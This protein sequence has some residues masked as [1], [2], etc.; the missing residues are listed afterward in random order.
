MG[1]GVGLG[2]SDQDAA[3]TLPD[4]TADFDQS[5]A[6]GLDLSPSQLGPCQPLAKRFDRTIVSLWTVGI[7]YLFPIP[8]SAGGAGQIK[9][10]GG[11]NLLTKK[12]WK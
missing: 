11:L 8:E 6:Q 12:N 7:N 2:A 9:H 10:A 4:P 5:F 3:D 1:P